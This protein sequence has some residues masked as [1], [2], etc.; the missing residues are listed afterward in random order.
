[1][2]EVKSYST[3]STID[4]L[5]NLIEKNDPDIAK[6]YSALLSAK[7]GY[8]NAKPAYNDELAAALAEPDLVKTI[9]IADVATDKF[10]Q[11]VKAY[12]DSA[13]ALNTQ[14]ST[15]AD[16]AMNEANANSSM[17]TVVL[18]VV[19][20]VAAVVAV[21]IGI[22]ISNGISR[23][24]SRIT[25]WVRQTGNEGSLQITQADWEYQKFRSRTCL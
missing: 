13:V 8:D 2:D 16:A 23:P 18:I 10:Q 11:Y 24:L 1:M 15:Y 3:S 22:V 4:K 20:G 14:L 21:T 19:L 7:T 9:Q 5:E 12:I 17:L 25:A 6:A